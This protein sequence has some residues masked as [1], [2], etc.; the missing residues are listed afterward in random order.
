MQGRSY[1]FCFFGFLETHTSQ[2]KPR[3]PLCALVLLID[4]RRHSE[5]LLEIFREML[6]VVET[7]FVGYLRHIELAF[8]QILCGTLQAQDAYELYRSFTREL[9]QALEQ[10]DTAHAEM[11]GKLLDRKSGAAHV[12]VNILHRLLYELLVQR[13]NGKRLRLRVYQCAARPSCATQ[14]CSLSSVSA[15]PC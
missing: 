1:F 4:G 8:A 9:L 7:A 3:F 13:S 10:M 2:E 15:H 11:R 6:R 5:L 14:V 12:L